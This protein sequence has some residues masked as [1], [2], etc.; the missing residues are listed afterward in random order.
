MRVALHGHLDAEVGQDLLRAAKD[1]AEFVACVEALNILAHAHLGDAT[2]CKEQ[3]ARSK[4]Q[5]AFRAKSKEQR[6]KKSKEQKAKKSK[7]EQ[8]AAPFC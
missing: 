8:R 6:A 3:R 2:A 4:E 7:E 5:G 1:G